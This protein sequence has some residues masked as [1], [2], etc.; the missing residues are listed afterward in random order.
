MAAANSTLVPAYV[1]FDE[2]AESYDELFT[3]SLIGSMQR[4]AVWRIMRHVFKKGDRVLEINCG[5]GADALFL[6][7]H[8]IRVVACD[9]SSRMVEVAARRVEA[10]RPR[11]Q[12]IV[13]VLRTEEIATLKPQ[14]PFDGLLSNF[15][16]LNCVEDLHH[17]FAQAAVLLRRDAA[18]VLC[19]SSRICAWEMAWFSLR[20]RLDLATRRLSGHT[21]ARIRGC[22]T[23]V[24]YPSISSVQRAASPWFCIELVA[25][26][27]VTVPPSYVEVWARKH[28]KIL[29]MLGSVE[30]RISRWPVCRAI[31]DHYVLVLRRGAV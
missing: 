3:R 22:R 16:G 30:R 10:E 23:A 2:L 6:A 9:A 8:G 18:V 19:M 17:F 7:R 5:T 24:S 4:A 31:G 14:A 27:G 29:R 15:A 26:V 12:A 20:G 11:E 13:Q 21:I 25:G 28:A 1:A